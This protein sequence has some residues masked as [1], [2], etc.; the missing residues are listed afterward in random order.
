MAKRKSGT[1]LFDLLGEDGNRQADQLKI[2][3]WW[4][5]GPKPG[6]RS[7][8]SSAAPGEA[9]PGSART[10]TTEVLARSEDRTQPGPL[11]ELDGE[12]VRVALTV[13]RA[14]MA[15][16]LVVALLVGIFEWG[17]RSGEARGSAIGY[18]AGRASYVAD[19]RDEIEAARSLPPAT[20]LVAGLLADEDARPSDDPPERVDIPRREAAARWVKGNTYVVAQEFASDSGDDAARAQAFLTDNGI[21][22][23]AVALPNGRLQLITMDGYNLADQTQK[24]LA[25]AL[26]SRVRAAGKRYFASGGRYRLEGYLKTLTRESW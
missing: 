22:C 11:F 5:R 17:S 18:E 12:V 26:R 15:I 4:G 14:A 3:G 13:K 2:P 9:A 19:A 20:Q 21:E 10:R 6:E 16:F 25:E 1:A 23:K 8:E 24:N 7:A